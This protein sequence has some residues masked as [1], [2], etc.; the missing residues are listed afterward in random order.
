MEINKQS[1]LVALAMV[2]PISTAQVSATS[3]AQAL[4]TITVL[5]M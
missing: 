5:A 1:H 2:S 4:V 3:M